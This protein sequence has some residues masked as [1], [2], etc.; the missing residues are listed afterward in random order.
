MLVKKAKAN[1]FAQSNTFQALQE[2]EEQHEP[3]GL[4]DIDWQPLHFH[5]RSLSPAKNAWMSRAK[6]RSMGDSSR[7]VVMEELQ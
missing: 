1:S 2:L 4:H 6:H 7:S 3:N 5:S